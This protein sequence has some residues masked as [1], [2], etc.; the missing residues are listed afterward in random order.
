MCV[1]YLKQTLTTQLSLRASVL[2]R[3]AFVAVQVSEHGN[4]L[5]SESFFRLE[6]AMPP[7]LHRWLARVSAHGAGND[8]DRSI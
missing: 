6:I 3:T 2:H 5:F 1:L 4:L 8:M 7:K